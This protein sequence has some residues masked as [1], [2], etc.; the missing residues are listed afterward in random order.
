VKALIA[1]AGIGGLAAAIAL[2]TAGYDVR[3]YERA[4]SPRALGFG[5]LLAPNALA[6]LRELQVADWARGEAPA[7]GGAELRRL[8]G[9]VIRR[10][11]GQLGGPLVVALRNDLHDALL[12]AVG[13]RALMFGREVVGFTDHGRLVSVMTADGEAE[14]VDLLIGADGVDSNIRRLLHPGEPPA[15][16]SGYC[17]VRGVAYGAGDVLGGLRAVGYL[18]DGVEAAA[19]RASHESKDAIYW[20]VSLLSKDVDVEE[21]T[22]PN[23]MDQ[24]MDE[25]E[26]RLQAIVAATRAEDMRFDELLEREPLRAWGAGRVTL[27]GDA[28]HPMLPHTGQG[29]AQALEDAVALGLAMSRSRSVQEGLRRYEAVRSRRTRRFVRLGPRIARLTTTRKRSVQALRTAVLRVLPERVATVSL[30]RQGRDPHR[31]LR[32]GDARPSCDTV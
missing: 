17:A 20:Y 27:L 9:S 1:G 7:P 10:F 26:G 18:D 15:R 21:R 6:A 25:F 24:R 30:L 3:V 16:P 22:A 23:V 31:S 13:E 29:A 12:Q 28:A 4:A 11:R 14:T 5:L 2:R 8:N 19:V 32:G